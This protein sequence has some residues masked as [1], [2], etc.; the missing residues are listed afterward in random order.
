MLEKLFFTW[1][2]IALLIWTLEFM[3]LRRFLL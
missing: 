2:P 3:I 1:L